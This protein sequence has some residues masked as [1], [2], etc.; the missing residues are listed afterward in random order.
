MFALNV[1]KNKLKI[2]IIVICVLIVVICALVGTCLFKIKQQK[3]YVNNQKEIMEKSNELFNNLY[4]DL[5]NLIPN[6]FITLTNIEE[7]ENNLKNV[8]L[9]E[10][11][12]D[13]E[14]LLK[15]LGEL[16]KYIIVKDKINS[17]MDKDVL[18]SSIDD[19][20]IKDINDKYN[21]LFSNYKALIEDDINLMNEQYKNITEL[22]QLVANFFEDEKRT[23]VSSSVTRKSY[24]EAIKKLEL[25][26]Q[27]DVKKNISEYLNIVDESLK[28]KEQAEAQKKKEEE[29]IAK[30]WKI[31]DVPYISQNK[32]NVLNGCEVSSLL[33]ALKYKG[34][35][36]DMD[37]WTYAENLPKSD[38]PY[39]GFTYSIFEREPLTVPHW[40]APGPL[41]E[42]GRK[43]SSAEVLDI[44]GYSIDDIDNEI[45]K[46]NPVVIYLTSR[47]ATPKEM[48]E[49]APLNL[50][51]LLL[52]GYNTKTKEHLIIDPWTQADGRTKWYVSKSKVESIFNS[53]G[54]RAVVVR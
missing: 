35:L 12:N 21:E 31:L 53:T 30:A 45:L 29:E 18:L 48:V 2:N 47:M 52:A 51:V 46:G 13:K 42:Y 50:H 10:Y 9:D 6:S 19:E 34:Y 11:T 41:A 24:N 43:T 40:I 39:K 20:T 37:L 26:K 22:N 14:N 17:Y 28:K 16:K 23:V 4:E 27:E 8:V 49:G 36:L 3:D 1:Q 38:D 32:N 54:Q 5:N 33:M 44:T 25:I 15:E 7:V